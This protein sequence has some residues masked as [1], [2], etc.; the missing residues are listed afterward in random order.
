MTKFFFFFC[1]HLVP[2]SPILKFQVCHVSAIQSGVFS[3]TD[4]I[5]QLQETFKTPAVV[6]KYRSLQA[7]SVS[8][9][10][11]F[12]RTSQ[13]LFL[14]DHITLLL[15]ISGDYL[16]PYCSIK[17]FTFDV[18]DVLN[19]IYSAVTSLHCPSCYFNPDIPHPWREEP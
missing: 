3:S 10:Q 18:H 17:S 4:V 5:M 12:S 9:S 15:A 7:P 13:V 14:L 1:H 16:V 11:I 6:M 2:F 8:F 19:I